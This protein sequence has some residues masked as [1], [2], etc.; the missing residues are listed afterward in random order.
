M[1]LHVLAD[2]LWFPD[3]EQAL[4]EPDGLLA[5]GGDLAPQRLIYAYQNAI[6][7]WFDDHQPILWWSPS[8]R[9]ILAPK[10]AHV[11]KSMKKW[12][13]KTP[14]KVSVNLA[15]AQVMDGCADRTQEG[16]W[17]TDEMKSAYI[18]LHQ[19]GFAH[20]IE[21]WDDERLVGGL[22]GVNIGQIYCGESM[23]HRETNAS[24]MAFIYLADLFGRYGGQYIDAQMPT[25]HLQSLGV[26]SCS[27]A[28]F[29]KYVRQ[30]RNQPLQ[31]GC[32]EPRYL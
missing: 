31:P 15:F 2:D 14:F 32:W 16:T 5:I 21:I 12:L 22:Y 6:F 13:K 9:A 30:Y 17:I 29:L 3:I 26:I 4:D 1:Q 28:N 27:R 19:Q 25:E 24:K 18:D 20:S 23:F 11:S 7:P 10:E 8:T